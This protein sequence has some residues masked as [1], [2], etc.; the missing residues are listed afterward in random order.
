MLERHDPMSK[1]T[2]YIIYTFYYIYNN[3]YL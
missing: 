1:D 2:V 3:V